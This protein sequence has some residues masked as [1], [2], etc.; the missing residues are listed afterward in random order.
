MVTADQVGETKKQS[1]C[2]M[3]G[4]GEEIRVVAKIEYQLERTYSFGACPTNVGRGGKASLI[5][6]YGCRGR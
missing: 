2:E 6:M 4:W 1:G 3:P 5:Y